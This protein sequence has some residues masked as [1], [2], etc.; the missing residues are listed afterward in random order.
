VPY[1]LSSYFTGNSLHLQH[2][3]QP[4]NAIITSF[5]P[6][7][8]HV[9]PPRISVCC[10]N[11]TKHLNTSILSG[12]FRWGYISISP[13][14]VLSESSRTI[15]VINASVKEDRGEAKVTHPQA[16]C[17]SMSLETALWTCILFTRVFFRLHVSLCLRFDGKIDQN[18]CLKCCLKLGKSATDINEILNEEFR[19][20]SLNGLAAFEW[21][22]VSRPVSGSWRW[23][24][25]ATKRQHNDIKCWKDLKIHPR[26]PPSNNPWT[27]QTPLGS[28]VEFAQN[29]NK[30]LNTRLIAAEF[31]PRLLTNDQKQRRIILLSWATREG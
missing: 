7:R 4:L 23:T 3:D 17:I 5:I 24:F 29:L 10:E 6:H 14:K 8:K 25:R 16:Y 30:I 15:I 31:V 1:K 11:H 21:H 2:K 9:I 18:V 22:S 13:F 27:L 28:V 20:Y 12:R 26:R 19:K